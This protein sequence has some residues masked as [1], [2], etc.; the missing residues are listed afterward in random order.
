MSKEIL[1]CNAMDL[2][3]D[4]SVEFKSLA[5]KK[6][7]NGRGSSAIN[8][9]EDSIRFYSSGYDMMIRFDKIIPA[10]KGARYSVKFVENPPEE[11]IK[12]HDDIK[13]GYKRTV[14]VEKAIIT[15]YLIV[16]RLIKIDIEINGDFKMKSKTRNVGKDITYDVKKMKFQEPD[17]GNRL[18]RY[19][20]F[21]QS[22]TYY[23]E[24]EFDT[25]TYH[26]MV[27][28]IKEVS[29]DSSLSADVSETLK[30]LNLFCNYSKPD[31]Q[32]TMMGHAIFAFAEKFGL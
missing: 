29:S 12:Y 22:N 1:K 6:F 20:D 18:I 21:C 15:G 4:S 9:L 13:N 32:R 24:L 7:P 10:D 23:Y 26:S 2:A 30:T 19:M 8:Q 11:F 31:E 17:F 27:E 28:L 3:R 25:Y 5:L 16:F 14:Y